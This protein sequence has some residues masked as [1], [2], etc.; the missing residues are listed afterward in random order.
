ML[1]SV[2]LSHHRR[3]G[4]DA[5]AEKINR[6]RSDRLDEADPPV[7]LA[8]LVEERE[9]DGGL[10]AVLAGAGDEDLPGSYNFV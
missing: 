8:G 1:Q 5:A 9:A 10:A 3:V 7:L 6:L 4:I 2:E